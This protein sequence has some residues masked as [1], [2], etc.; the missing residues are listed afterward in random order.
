MSSR[1]LLVDDEPTILK[2]LSEFLSIKGYKVTELQ[3]GARALLV[4]RAEMPDV[5]L[6][7]IRMPDIDGLVVLRDIRDFDPKAHVIMVTAVP[8]REVKTEA[9]NSGA[10]SFVNKPIDLEQLM[11]LLAIVDRVAVQEG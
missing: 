9:L 5:V 2:A 6:L 4:Y 3:H 11:F 10:S 1:I 8:E 7:D